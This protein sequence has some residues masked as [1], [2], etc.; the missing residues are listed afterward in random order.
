MLL[1]RKLRQDN[2]VNDCKWIYTKRIYH[3]GC[4][5]N[6]DIYENSLPAYKLAIEKKSPIEL[7]VQLTNDLQV[8]CFHDTG[9]KRFFNRERNVSDISYKRLN[10]LRGDLQVPLLEDVLRYVDGKVELMIELKHTSSKLNKILVKKVCE[11]LKNYKG[12]YVIVSFNPFI[13]R[14]YRKLNKDAYRGRIYSNK[15]GK[16]RFITSSKLFDFIAKPDFISYDINEYKESNLQR[17]KDKGYKIV[18]WP[19]KNKDDEK[20]LKK[21]FDNF[22]IEY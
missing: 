13:L 9:L 19:S 20:S 2:F 4:F 22:I 11:L 6:I 16:N 17:Y 5:N 12:K 3:R 8:V 15:K 7:D 21:Y 14:Q 10:K 18:G 1:K